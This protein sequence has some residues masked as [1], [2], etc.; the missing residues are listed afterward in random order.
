MHDYCICD[1]CEQE[2][3]ADYKARVAKLKATGCE[4]GHDLGPLG[5][6]RH[7]EPPAWRWP[8]NALGEYGRCTRCGDVRALPWKGI[9]VKP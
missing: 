4:N 8:G 7:G 2:R 9:T 5:P 1:A 6:Y 3:D